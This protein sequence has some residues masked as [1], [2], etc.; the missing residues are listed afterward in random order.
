MDPVLSKYLGSVDQEWLNH[1]LED[2]EGE[3]WSV[4][5]NSTLIGVVGVVLPT[6]T[7]NYFT[8]TNMA[9]CPNLRNKGYGKTILQLLFTQYFD[10]ET[11]KF[12]CYVDASNSLAQ[13]F[14]LKNN[15]SVNFQ[16]VENEM[17]LFSKYQA[18][19]TS[20]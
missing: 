19:S 13:Q 11:K 2:H 18:T 14:F 16:I 17:V 15:W 4:I 8:I 12:V 3:E 9:V 10:H 1:V 6:A 7:N 20:R 5:E